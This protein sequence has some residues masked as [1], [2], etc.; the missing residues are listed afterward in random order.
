[1]KY[2]VFTNGIRIELFHDE[3]KLL[4]HMIQKGIRQVEYRKCDERIQYNLD[5]LL[6]KNILKRKNGF[7]SLRSDFKILQWG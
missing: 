6:R 5:A 3:Y 4:N 1:M 2:A 7:Y